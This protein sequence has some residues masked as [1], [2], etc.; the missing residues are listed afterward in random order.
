MGKIILDVAGSI[1]ENEY[2]ST[3]LS[4]IFKKE[5]ADGSSVL[6]MLPQQVTRYCNKQFILQQLTGNGAM[7]IAFRIMRF[8]HCEYIKN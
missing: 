8:A 4:H 2:G 1:F 6:Y 7:M 3:R 5:I